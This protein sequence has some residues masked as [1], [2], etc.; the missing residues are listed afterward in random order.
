MEELFYCGKY[1]E[2]RWPTSLIHRSE[3]KKGNIPIEKHGS[4]ELYKS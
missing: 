2:E 3:T 4:P 1:F